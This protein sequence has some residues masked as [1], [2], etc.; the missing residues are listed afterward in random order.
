MEDNVFRKTI[1]EPGIKIQYS[2]TDQSSETKC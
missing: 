1:R 2:S